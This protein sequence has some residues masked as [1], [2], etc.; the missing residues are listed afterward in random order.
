M[1]LD[2]DRER[3][4]FIRAEVWYI[5]V[6]ADVMMTTQELQLKTKPAEFFG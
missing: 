1:I 3:P 5:N 4:W 6:L 2:Q